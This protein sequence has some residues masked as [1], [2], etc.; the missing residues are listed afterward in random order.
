[1][2]VVPPCSAG[3]FIPATVALEC[4]VTHSSEEGIVAGAA[5]DRVSSSFA[6]YRVVST[7]AIADIVAGAEAYRV[8][9]A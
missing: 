9:T 6:E 2:D 5:R 7:S 4:V 8:V 3:K 1:M